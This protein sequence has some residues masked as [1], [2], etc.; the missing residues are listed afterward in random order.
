MASTSRPYISL[1][2]NEIIEKGE[3][4]LA[5]TN[6]DKLRIL[7][8]EISNRKRAEKKLSSIKKKI[9]QQ[10]SE[11]A[12]SPGSSVANFHEEDKQNQIYN[13]GGRKKI[14]GQHRVQE[15]SIAGDSL[16][17]KVESNYLKKHPLPEKKEISIHKI[18]KSG[19]E[20]IG[21]P[22]PLV[23]NLEEG[24]VD[25]LDSSELS[26]KTWA[27]R[28][29]HALN[30]RI[31]DSK[32]NN[33]KSISF[34][35]G[36]KV[37]GL[38]SAEDSIAYVVNASSRADELFPGASVVLRTSNAKTDGRVVAIGG[39]SSN[40]VTLTVEEDLGERLNGGEI[41]IDDTAIDMFIRD[42]LA[43]ECGIS[44][45]GGKDKKPTKRG[46][47]LDFASNVLSNQYQLLDEP[48]KASN[49]EKLNSSQASFIEKALSYNISILWGPPG[50]GKTQTLTSV[51]KNLC[52]AG[53]K[54]LI[55]SNTNMAVDQVFLKCCRE[56]SRLYVDENKF[57]RIG[58]ISHKD[59]IRDHRE[60]VTVEG[61]SEKLGL[62]FKEEIDQLLSQKNHLISQSSD[63]LDKSALFDELDRIAIEIQRSKAEFLKTQSA[64]KNVRDEISSLVNSAN[65]LQQKHNERNSG[66]GGLAGVFGRSPETLRGEINV[67]EQDISRKNNTLDDYRSKL[68]RLKDLAEN[69]A[70]RDAEVSRQ[71]H[72]IDRDSLN[73]RVSKIKEDVANIDDKCRKLEE[74]LQALKKTIIENSLVVGTTLAKTCMSLGDLGFYDNVIID[75]ASMASLPMLFVATSIAKKRVIISGDFSQLSPI[76]ST[77]NKSIKDI[78]GKSIF[79]VCGVEEA[80]R[81]G[82]GL[83]KNLG[84]LDTQYRM[85]PSICNLI[86]GYMYNNQLHSGLEVDPI[87]IIHPL[88]DSLGELVLIDTSTL[89]S[90]SSTPASGG[91]V[92]LLHAYIARKLLLQVADSNDLSLGYCTPF[93]GQS[94]LF[95]KLLTEQD[96]KVISSVGTVHQFQ[97]DERDLLVFDTV[98]AQSESQFLAPFINATKPQDEGAKNLNVAISRAKKSLIVLADLNVLDKQLSNYSFLREVLFSMQ[99]TG[100]V[101]DARTLVDKSELGIIEA[102]LSVSQISVAKS[103]IQDGMADETSFFPLLY[104]NIEEAKK[105]IIIF[106]GFFTPARVDEV[107]TVLRKPLKD[108]VKVKFV[109]PTNQ[110]NGSFGKS[111]PSKS[112]D[113]I[114]L[115]RDRGV[116]VEQR[117]KLHQK[118]VLIDEDLA[119]YGSLN[120]L[121]FAGSTLESML[122]VRQSGI[123]LELASSLSLPG[124]VKPS[125]MV[126]WAQLETPECP[127]CGSRTV[128]AKSRYGA[129][130]PCED[131]HCN[132][133]AHGFRR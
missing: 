86:S 97:G 57:V 23:F 26:K 120:P 131:T 126:D 65:E 46:L 112:F 72:G 3:Q 130:F 52:D 5:S 50:T 79:D 114:R 111:D 37:V 54:T 20:L 39:A 14:S 129:Y 74:S 6:T 2:T 17:Q 132:G 124:S 56:D 10:L 90:F 95:S 1:K 91:K 101:I 88:I 71:L 67:L 60:K 107:L 7:L 22:D 113:L 36:K 121:S 105:S 18:R 102:E 66:R 127:K 51:I 64:A 62:E 31:S 16:I 25:G 82:S 49:L 128:Y 83:S 13:Q 117:K 76:C 35:I 103:S 9:E 99:M 89:L 77:K 33:S 81:S 30:Q 45:K 84:F 44:K 28:F 29:Y 59:L 123:A 106:S 12:A 93:A 48:I 96:Q 8:E 69:F 100:R 118:A 80:V 61:I 70:A 21:T 63:L 92:N 122:L 53:E 24:L 108:G 40:E 34:Q 38:T 32:K 104:K 115:I 125:S 133:K 41:S 55:C 4:L 15:E 43:K 98:V 116:V 42:L 110:T 11:N 119:W 94:R 109:L 47:L 58:N 68:L 75:E 85:Q 73:A 27:E 87:N 78:L 19:P